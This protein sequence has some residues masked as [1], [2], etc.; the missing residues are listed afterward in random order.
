MSLNT[1]SLIPVCRLET[2]AKTFVWQALVMDDDASGSNF[3]TDQARYSGILG[4]CV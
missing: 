2:L 3:R 4:D 1:Y